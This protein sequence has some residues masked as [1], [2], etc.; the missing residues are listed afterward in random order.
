MIDFR[1]W[2]EAVDLSEPEAARRLGC[3]RDY[4]ASLKAAPGTTRHR[5]MSDAIALRCR[6]VALERVVEFR[7]RINL[8]Q[9]IVKETG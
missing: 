6:E 3:S 2:I 9:A 1:A 5:P 4:V 8:I 7:E